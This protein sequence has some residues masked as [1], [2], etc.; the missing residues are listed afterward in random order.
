MPK[1]KRFLDKPKD[2]INALI[3]QKMLIQERIAEI[4]AKQEEEK[5]KKEN[6]K[7]VDTIDVVATEG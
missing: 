1:K 6:D 7:V 5:E 3:I 2:F 4:T